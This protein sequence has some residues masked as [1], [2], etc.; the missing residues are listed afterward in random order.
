MFHR[1]CVKLYT[2]C[3]NILH[4][5]LTVYTLWSGVHLTKFGRNMTFLMQIDLWLTSDRMELVRKIDH[6]PWGPILYLYAKFQLHVKPETQWNIYAW[7]T[8]RQT[9][10]VIFI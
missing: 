4:N 5:G 9:E 3:L 1:G 6:E 7:Y 10:S 2:T 8:D